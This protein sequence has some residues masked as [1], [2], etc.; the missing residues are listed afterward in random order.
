MSDLEVRNL[1]KQFDTPAGPLNILTGVQLD[2]N[3]GDAVAVTGPSGCGKSTLLYILGLLDTP[4]G[5]SYRLL[6]RN[7]ATLTSVEQADLRNRQI[8]FIFQDHHLLPQCSVLENVLLP[9]LA[10]GSPAG[11]LERALKLIDQV[12]LSSRTHHRPTKLSGGER[13][14]VAV[15]RAL[16]NQ[17]TLLLADE[18]TGSLDPQTASSV[19]ELLLQLAA[20][21]N[22]LLICVTHSRELA[23]RFPRH[24]Q[25]EAGQLVSTA[26]D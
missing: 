5:G 13:Q 23:N 21:Q 7:C 4:S 3:R 9:T 17:P 16:I 20:E 22:T 18:P 2:L 1:Q 10:G 14:R 6:E 15:C 25:L 8:G 11:A 26:A 24:L 12:G 19:G